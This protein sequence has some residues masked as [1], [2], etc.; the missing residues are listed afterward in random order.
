MWAYHFLIAKQLSSTD[1]D[2]IRVHHQQS[3]QLVLDEILYGGD[4]IITFGLC[5]LRTPQ[6]HLQATL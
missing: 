5:H 2:T 3:Y 4:P 1:R 6:C